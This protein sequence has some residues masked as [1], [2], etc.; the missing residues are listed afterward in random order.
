MRFISGQ[1][2]TPYDSTPC[3]ITVAYASLP[4]QCNRFF[5]MKPIYSRRI[6]SNLTSIRKRIC[7]KLAEHLLLFSND[8]LFTMFVSH[9]LPFSYA[10]TNISCTRD[11]FYTYSKRTPVPITT[12]TRLTPTGSRRESVPSTFLPREWTPSLSE[13]RGFARNTTREE[14]ILMSNYINI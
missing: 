12:L 14:E 10:Q 7:L 4:I 8:F 6:E 1:E 9:A 11:Y 5:G 3:A 2:S 13:T